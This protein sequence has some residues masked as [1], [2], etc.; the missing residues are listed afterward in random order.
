MRQRLSVAIIV[1]LLIVI[2]LWGQYQ[3]SPDNLTENFSRPLY[4]V[5]SLFVLEGG[6]TLDLAEIPVTIEIARF[7]APLVA[8]ASLILAFP[9]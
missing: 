6:W 9:V 2:G 4:E 7:L 1:L 5:V 3:V 8:I